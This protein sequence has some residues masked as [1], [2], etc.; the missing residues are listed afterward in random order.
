MSEASTAIAEAARR[1]I[2]E[3]PLRVA[4][5]RSNTAIARF[6]DD[7]LIDGLAVD[8]SGVVAARLQVDVQY[9]LYDNAPAIVADRDGWHCAF[10]AADRAASPGLVLTEPYLK[11]EAVLA[12]PCKSAAR[13]L[14]DLDRRETVIASVAGS[15]FGKRLAGSIRH[16]TIVEYRSPAEAWSALTSGNATACAGLRPAL[17]RASESDPRFRIME[18]GFATLGQAIAVPARFPMLLR[19]ASDCVT[20]IA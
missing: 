3:G 11:L 16:A 9:A 14:A 7:G 20:G 18:H 17:T 15:A 19:L 12:L 2:G 4:L 8:L 6:H 5:N 1:E 10:I 13:G